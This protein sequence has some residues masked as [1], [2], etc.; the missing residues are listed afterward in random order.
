MYKFWRD[1]DCDFPSSIYG[2]TES[3][4]KGAWR[5]RYPARHIASK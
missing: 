3:S 2:S 1:V 5:H 4:N